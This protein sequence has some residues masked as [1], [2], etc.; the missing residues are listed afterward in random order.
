MSHQPTGCRIGFLVNPIAGM[1]GAVGL[2]GT[3]GRLYYEALAR[4]AKPVAPARAIRFLTRL[5]EICPSSVELLLAG[6]TMGCDYASRVGLDKYVCLDIP[7][8]D[9]TTREDTML[10]VREFLRFRVS[11][12]VFV[13]GD[14]TARDVLEASSGSLPALGVPSGVKVYSSVFAVSPEAAADIVSDYCRG[15]GYIDVGDVVD[16][17]E[18][19][20]QR[21]VLVLKPFGRMPTLSS[22]NL[23]VHT[24]EFGTYED[25]EG[26][27]EYF[28][29]EVY[30]P[31]V[32]Y[33]IGPGSTTKAIASKL[34]IEKTLL[35]FDAVLNGKVIGKDLSE[36]DI[37][38][39][40]ATF[41][42]VYVVLSII[43]GQG[44]LIG[45]GNQQLT[46]E[47]LRLLGK[48]RIIVVS[49]RSKLSRVRYLLIDSG[50]VE[51]DKELSGFYRVITGFGEMYVIKALPASDPKALR[52]NMLRE[53]S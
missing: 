23:K 51:V 15:E 7:S 36:S 5:K 6:G 2:K 50:D 47:V 22:G 33:I 40:I 38:K 44:Y 20:M 48:D 45:R 24:K 42:D 9:K 46:P 8:S 10:V 31:G 41:K 49:S 4:G 28:V 18:E 26:L 37:K 39:L 21:D 1:G 30:K 35:G 17:N 53:Q 27:A 14:G 12:I 25:I 13:G 3:D 29:S 19:A 16:V 32:L 34:G 43:G 52:L 11:A